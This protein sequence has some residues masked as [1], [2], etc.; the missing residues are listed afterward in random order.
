[1]SDL[2]LVSP[3]FPTIKTMSVKKTIS[4][5]VPER[6]KV[7]ELLNLYKGGLSTLAFVLDDLKKI[8]FTPE[9]M[10][11]YEIKT[12]PSPD[13]P[14]S[15]N[16]NWNA[17]K[18]TPKDFEIS[19]ESADFMFAEIDKKDKAGEFGRGDEIFI[20]LLEKVK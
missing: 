11:E 17:T 14:G 7:T 5:D 15:Y 4:L 20:T 16:I 8:A 10:T 3:Y 12:T 9:E 2:Q 13:V 18:N 6:F 19:K 1:M